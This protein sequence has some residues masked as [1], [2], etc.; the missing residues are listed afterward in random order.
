[1]KNRN[2]RPRRFTQLLGLAT[3]TLATAIGTVIF[4]NQPPQTASSLEVS[5]V[6]APEQNATGLDVGA[7]SKTSTLLGAIKN[8]FNTLLNGGNASSTVAGSPTLRGATA[9]GATPT[10]GPRRMLAVKGAPLGETL[11]IAGLNADADKGRVVKLDPVDAREWKNLQE[12]DVFA[13]PTVAGDL[14]E[15]T[16]NVVQEDGGWARVGGA[17]A[18]GKGSFSLNT[19]G[20][21]V[22]GMILLP[23]LGMGYKI[24]RD[25]TDFL[26][27]E[28][29]LSTLVCF[30]AVISTRTAITDGVAR[31]A[32]AAA[33]NV[34]VI[35]TRPGAKGVIFVDFDG[36]SVTDPVWNN[37]RTIN[38]APST[39]SNDQISQVLAICA[40]D[41]APFDITLTTDS[42]LYAATPSGR[43]MHVVVTPTD[44]AAPGSGGVAYVDCWSGAGRSFRSDVVC[45]VFNQ[46]VKSVAESVSHEVGHTLG[47]NH[48][49]QLGGTEYYAGNGGGLTTPT[50]WAPI[51][52]VGY[53]RNLVQWSKGEYSLA[54]NTEDDVAIIAR[55]AN[56]VGFVQ[57]ELANVL[58]GLPVNGGTFAAEGLLRTADSVDTFQFSTAGGQLVA[59][60]GP[61]SL[62]SDVD[63]KL[64][65]TDLAGATIVLSDLPT[66]LSASINRTLAAGTYKLSVRAAAS[67]V[68][69][70]GGYVTGYSAYGSQGRY[71]L[72][73]NLQGSAVLP[74]FTSSPAISG[75][76]GT[77]LSAKLAVSAATSVVVVSRS[78]PAGLTFDLSSLLLSGTPLLE[79]G[80]G[81]IGSATGP[82]LLRLSA[83]NS[84]GTVTQ[85]F[86]ITIAK[87]GLPLSDAFPPNSGT[88][89]NT[90]A[91]P[92][93]GVS[94][95]RADGT[96]G[97]VAQSGAIANNGWTTL[98]FDYT[99]PATLGASNSATSSSVLTFY[100]K[101]S[102]EALSNRNRYGDFVQCQ[103]NGR[104]AADTNSGEQ[105]YISG[106]TGWIRQT[107]RLRG[108]GA[109]RVTFTY[110][111]DGSLSKG[112]D[113]VWVYA[114]SIGQPPVFTLQPSAVRLSSGSSAFT[115]TTAVIGADSLVWKKDFATLANGTSSSGST[116]A[117]ATAQSL[118][119]SKGSSADAGYYWLEAKNAFGSVICNPV[120]VTVAAL[121]VFTQ[122]PIAPS[123]LKLG[124]TLT[125]SA[126]VSGG[127]PLNYQWI[128]DGHPLR[129]AFAN[130]STISLVVS[131]ITAAAAGTYTLSVWNRY[132][133]VNS[134]SVTVVL[135]TVQSKLAR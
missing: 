74:V 111:K 20:E 2:H 132:G 36:E 100:W 107:V 3:I 28:R 14:L 37:G 77:P 134:D 85:D 52:G 31:K 10:G 92:W 57:G 69:P 133:T 11:P 80:T 102:T 65:L 131:K 19:N 95:I 73:G 78:L 18:D 8:A 43:R 75:M 94:M 56:Q 45:W 103:V 13:L 24:E 125:L 9:A 88:S 64:E 5:A 121:P 21:E 50:S 96:K 58:K 1:M 72:S 54:N 105:L 48:D 128:K 119:V 42:A 117:G 49:G 106:E 76:A 27:V 32:V 39:L 99:V 29:R 67:G 46:S 118:T 123:G 83:S 122:Q 98:T 51:M 91:A 25:G 63:V 61:S 7:A 135:G 38:A 33:I 86:V 115:L 130:S 109:Q 120:E 108:A 55:A 79:T 90:A 26:L 70:S 84:T 17:L 53:S 126:T 4:Q 16:V 23:E 104:L 82:G 35:N 112:Q 15:G 129:A 22:S 47:L 93:T 34:P 62:N 66:S 40:Q 116:I 30:P 71:T 41:Y 68:K 60:A 101:A 124:D 44:S 127:T 81:A 89:S 114:T 110:A 12:G 6:Q 97:T 87:G 59:T 113:R